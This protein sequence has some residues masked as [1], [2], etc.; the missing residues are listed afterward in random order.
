MSVSIATVGK[1][2]GQVHAIDV[3][4][5][6]RELSSGDSVHLDEV[7]STTARGYI[8]IQQAQGD[9]LVIEALQTVK[10]THDTFH[11][12]ESIQSDSILS[13]ALAVGLFQ[14]ILSDL[15]LSNT[16]ILT[17]CEPVFELAE[18]FNSEVTAEN[19][20]NGKVKLSL[21]DVLSQHSDSKVLDDF[22]RFDQ[23]DEGTIVYLSTQ[24]K[25]TNL[26]DAHQKAD[27]VITINS[28]GYDNHN[29]VLSY[30]LENHLIDLS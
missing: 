9:D 7:I 30:L 6:K 8:Q 13:G 16:S 10:L 2:E 5:A 28:T 11:H 29:E 24:G 23:V 21:E 12:E 27:Q 15:S 18:K 3:L 26:I 14:D 20:A 4:G 1:I 19:F 22:L 25:L 17:Q